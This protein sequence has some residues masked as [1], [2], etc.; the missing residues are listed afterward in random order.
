MGL[1]FLK[2]KQKKNMKKYLFKGFCFKLIKTFFWGSKKSFENFSLS[3]KNT[4]VVLA[5]S[6]FNA[7]K[8]GNN[9]QKRPKWHFW[10]LIAFLKC[11]FKNTDQKTVVRLFFFNLNQSRNTKKTFFGGYFFKTKNMLFEGSNIVV[12]KTQFRICYSAF[13]L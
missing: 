8:K 7:L 6:F 2:L 13:V 12:F 3:N 10:R 11:I 5:N 1:S 9:C 4:N